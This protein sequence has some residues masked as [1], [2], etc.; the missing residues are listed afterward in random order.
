MWLAKLKETNTPEENIA[1][2]EA[3]LATV[4][5]AI[6][7]AIADNPDNENAVRNALAEEL[8]VTFNNK[9]LLDKKNIHRLLFVV[10]QVKIYLASNNKEKKL[11]HRLITCEKLADELA[12]RLVL[13]QQNE[14]FSEFL[15]KRNAII[16]SYETKACETYLTKCSTL[17]KTS[18]K[19]TN[20]TPPAPPVC[21]DRP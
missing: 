11:D 14:N 18:K 5:P 6:H 16:K 12:T 8:Q 17:F 20:G 3:L 19:P 7:E 9:K 4:S 1:A 10:M 13:K 15:A 21:L 2:I